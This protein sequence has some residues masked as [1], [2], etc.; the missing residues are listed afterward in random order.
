M[1]PSITIITSTFNCAGALKLTAQSIR[2]QKYSSI[3]WIIADG[4]STDGTIEVINSNYEIISNWF[5]GKDTG[6][7]DAWNKACKFIVNEW[8]I[9]LGAGDVLNSS[10]SLAEFWSSAKVIG[11]EYKIVYGNVLYLD[12]GGNPRY[13]SR[14][15]CL[16]FWEFG[17]PALPHH[18]GIFQHK[19]LFNID[20]FDTS[21]RVAADSK[22]LLKSL[23]YCKSLH[24][25]ITLTR[26]F[27]DGI[28]NDI[29]N[30]INAEAE[31]KRVCRELEIYVPFFYQ[32]RADLKRR[33]LMIFNVIIP[34]RISVCIKY[35]IDKGRLL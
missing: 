32:I 34:R 11:S 29:K 28:S 31:I 12:Q 9:F 21:Y 30:L 2:S 25:D 17:R 18:Q 24:I 4:G 10:T 19:S 22:F 14:K 6:I 7:Y 26:M 33:L 16:K 1:Q 5:S 23:Q 20:T 27:A 35:L 3:Q 15:P 8:V 13:L